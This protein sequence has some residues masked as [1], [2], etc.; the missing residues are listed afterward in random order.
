MNRSPA[1]SEGHR[2][3]RAPVF[4]KCLMAALMVAVLAVSC[5]VLINGHTDESDAAYADSV[6]VGGR[7]VTP[8]NPYSFSNGY[9]TSTAS[10]DSSTGTLTL[11]E[12][13]NFSVVHQFSTY[14]YA[15]NYA[16]IY[17]SGDLNIV[18]T[19]SYTT[20][21][22][23]K[24]INIG[25]TATSDVEN[26][27]GIYAES[28]LTITSQ[29]NTAKISTINISSG[30][31][32]TASYAVYAGSTAQLSNINQK[33]VLTGGITNYG[34]DVELKS[35][36]M[37]AG[38]RSS[39]ITINN[40]AD[41]N[42]SAGNFI[43][44]SCSGG[45]GQVASYG[46]IAR[47][48]VT[49]TSSNVT[50][51]S[52]DI[53][54]TYYVNVYPI[55]TAGIYS[56][57]TVT[58]SGSAMNTVTVTAGDIYFD[59]D[60]EG[61]TIHGGGNSWGIFGGS[62]ELSGENVTATGGVVYLP[63]ILNRGHSYGIFLGDD[64]N[65]NGGYLTATGSDAA[66][67]SAGMY[68]Y[69][70]FTGK[71]NNATLT[72]GFVASTSNSSYSYGLKVNG[73]ISLSGSSRVEGIGGTICYR[74]YSVGVEARNI[75]L[76]SSS[77]LIGHGGDVSNTYT[78][79]TKYKDIPFVVTTGSS[80]DSYGIA[81]WGSVTVN[82]HSAIYCYGGSVTYPPSGGG[83]RIS[84]GLR[85]L[86][87]GVNGVNSIT[88]DGTGNVYAIGGNNT[89]GHGVGDE[90]DE[91]I[92]ISTRGT[93]L[94]I[95]GTG[96]IATGGDVVTEAGDAW[97][98]TYYF[99]QGS[100]S[101]GIAVKD[102][103]LENRATVKATGGPNLHYPIP[104]SNQSYYACHND[105]FGLYLEGS[106]TV[107]DSVLNATAS[108]SLRM[109]GILIEGGGITVNGDSSV[110]SAIV[111]DC[112][113]EG[114]LK[115][116]E[117][118]GRGSWGIYLHN[119]NYSSLNIVM[120]SGKLD[121][122]G[123]TKAIMSD[124]GSNTLSA[125]YILYGDIGAINMST[126]G[127]QVQFSS[128][129]SYTRHISTNYRTYTL[130]FNSNGGSG[131]MDSVEADIIHRLPVCG[132]T[133]PAGK[134][135]VGW[136]ENR[137]G[138][139]FIYPRYN[140]YYV[141]QNTR[142]YAIWENHNIQHV[143]AVEPTCTESG[144]TEHW[145]CEY[146]GGHFSDAAGTVPTDNTY[147]PPI[148]HDLEVSFDWADDGSTCTVDAVC[149]NDP[150]HVLHKVMTAESSIWSYP[151]CDNN[152]ST[153]YEIGEY[154]GPNW[155]AASIILDDIPALGHEPET[156][157]EAVPHTC[158][159]DGNIEYWIC[160]RCGGYFSDA[161]CAHEIS[162]N[163]TID[164]RQHAMEHH[165]LVAETCTTDGHDE[166][167]YCT[168]CEQYFWDENGYSPV[169]Y[170]DLIF[171][172]QHTLVFQNLEAENCTEDGHI[173]HY[174]C[175]VCGKYFQDSNGTV[176]LDESDIV[177]VAH[178]DLFHYD[179]VEESCY[180]DGYIEYWQC[181]QCG[182]YFID[183]RA[184][185]NAHLVNSVSWEQIER[186]AHHSPVL[187]VAHEATCAAEGNIA[188]WECSVCHVLFS[189]QACTHSIVIDDTIIAKKPH[190]VITDAAVAA[191]CTAPGLTQGSH[192]SVCGEIIEAQHETDALGHQWGDY[193]TTQAATCTATGTETR[194]CE[195]DHSHS[196]SRTIPMIDHSLTAHEAH[197]ATCT[198]DGNSAYWECTVCHRLFSDSDGSNQITPQDVI[199]AATGH[200]SVSTPTQD[201]T[202][203]EAGHTGG[204]HCSVCDAVLTLPTPTPALGHEWSDWTTTLEP[205]E[206]DEGSEHR[207]CS[208]C[209]AE[210]IRAIPALGHEHTPSA[211]AAVAS[212]CTVAGHSAYW[213]CTSC[214]RYFSDAECTNEIDLSSTE[215][216]LAQ[217][218]HVTIPGV[219]ATC[220][221]TGLTDGIKCSVCEL[222]IEERQV[223]PMVDHKLD[224]HAASDPTCTEN[225]NNEYWQCSDCHGYFSDA[226]GNTSITE[227]ATVRAATGHTPETDAYVAATCTSIGH[228]EGSHCSV[229]H[230][231]I[232]AQ[233]EIPMLAHTKVH[234]DAQ[235]ATCTEAGTYGYWECTVCHNLYSDEA[236]TQQMTQAQTVQAALG[237]D[238]Q[239]HDAIAA[240]CTIGGMEAYDTCSRCDY[241]SAH[242]PVAAIGHAYSA[243]YEWAVDG[244]S[245][246]VRIVCANDAAH[247]HSISDAVVESSVKSAATTT[248]M[249]VTTYSVS[250]TYDGFAYA[251]VKDVRNIP[252][253][254]PE[255]TQVSGTSTYANTVTENQATKVTEIFNTAKNNSGSVEVSVP[256]AAAGSMTIAFDNAAVNAIAS[257]DNVTLEATVRENVAE[258]A[259]AA[260][261]IEVT[262]SGATFSDGKAKV[263]VPFSQEV[264]S[265]KTVKV[266]FINGDQRQD[267]N[268]TLVDGNVV[269]E[270]SHF[271]TYAIVFE[272]TLSSDSN[273]GGFPIWIVAVIAV[274]AIAAVGGAFFFM[275]NK[276]A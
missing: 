139:G 75:T 200:T 65:C 144:N 47:G 130:S 255:I 73:N 46:L 53:D 230:A 113:K 138:S 136:S 13:Y 233:E 152:G 118:I 55:E 201:P 79:E 260:L 41:V 149:R 9:G 84:S 116:W 259:D 258:V 36:F 28:K 234:H 58:I 205:T 89:Y 189:D 183:E 43:A 141:G 131:T 214:H 192:C 151:D 92:G 142:L 268:A 153:R 267:M 170:Q 107:T 160:G 68:V 16:N 14:S 243:I 261:V 155:I 108:S 98:L 71:I 239:H 219:A 211:F 80:S 135:F 166:Y 207:T 69:G 176:E 236:C 30:N 273:G 35:S 178:H 110:I 12:F 88:G 96:V 274:V 94:R 204:T 114:S 45:A 99:A 150:E 191:T 64:F 19:G 72:G 127:S 122:E 185:T 76:S 213:E 57:G 124:T 104:G 74:M 187:H 164:R 257:G 25:P 269:F 125:T 31:A 148:G 247:N 202:C 167:W 37:N 215:L 262:L 97:G 40:C 62:M 90:L 162:F 132:F 229:C 249:G 120:N 22:P 50:A 208:R 117:N 194:Y 169:S 126:R 115:S 87:N 5:F 91:S 270:T 179:A 175:S 121:A 264:P 226:N 224:H 174:K 265:G 223:I 196:E 157:V 26:S 105:S 193:E 227:S 8:S 238:L 85:F 10:Y 242:S 254:E 225:G 195:R 275:K 21:Y 59:H 123:Y 103:I 252:A 154:Y 63:V 18:F 143:D 34:S 44:P 78:T 218:T 206:N 2:I 246:V 235:P 182:D 17:S 140:N 190:T 231:V 203:I 251:S 95:D 198:E 168:V 199:V 253:L 209:S 39:T 232:V 20:S 133:A 56:D 61:Q 186:P 263:T 181:N 217:H 101:T 52:G 66:L 137:E 221:S 173:A 6:W 159:R 4:R 197:A 145:Y 129:G 48:G 112:V 100:R 165:P 29:I 15:K 109:I 163:E 248:S 241:E 3:S 81:T 49:I 272:D 220:T 128:I 244:S 212:T 276:K 111:P 250:G 156:H 228:T 60:Y 237:H 184:G 171:P 240:T 172:A 93:S 83:S 82:T 222:V 106:L 33:L 216:P 180:S 245:C 24:T 51:R 86:G 1:R 11:D 102:L 146:C 271:S 158:T 134:H 210:E 23:T 256:T 27:Y 266:Y 38:L 119:Y 77:K 7:E 32:S 188:Y 67:E 177:I 42:A 161:Q 70:D 147:R 54:T